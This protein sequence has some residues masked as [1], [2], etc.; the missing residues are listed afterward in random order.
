MQRVEMKVGIAIQTMPR[1]QHKTLLCTR[2]ACQQGDLT[3]P[4]VPLFCLSGCG[5]FRPV[6]H[7]SNA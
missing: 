2:W 7:H 3:T 1:R 5:Y 6:V 4:I